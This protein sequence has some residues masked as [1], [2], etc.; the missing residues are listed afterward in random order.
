L[1]SSLQR[2]FV[3]ILANINTGKPSQDIGISNI[4]AASVNGGNYPLVENDG[5]SQVAAIKRLQH[6][7]SDKIII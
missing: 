5:Q 7:N 4:C 6:G 2:E 3:G 1:P